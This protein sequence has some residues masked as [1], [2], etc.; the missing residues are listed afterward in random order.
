M[1]NTFL[2]SLNNFFS[3]KMNRHSLSACHV[4]SIILTL[5][6]VIITKTPSSKNS[7][8]H[9]IFPYLGRH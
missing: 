1:I 4:P 3:M 8:C 6:H 2:S 9:I 7:F 5:S